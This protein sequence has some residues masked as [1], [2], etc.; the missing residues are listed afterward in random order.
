MNISNMLLTQHIILYMIDVTFEF[1]H[2]AS[3]SQNLGETAWTT[4]ELVESGIK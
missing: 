3:D 2:V 1:Q 4:V